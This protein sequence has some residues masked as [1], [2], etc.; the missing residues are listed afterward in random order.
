[1][2]YPEL[3]VEIIKSPFQNQAKFARAINRR[4]DWL[5]GLIHGRVRPTEADKDLIART[6][7]VP[8]EELF[9]G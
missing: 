1:M 7:G 3:K 2:K 8:Q 5:S 4:D 6:L 9:P